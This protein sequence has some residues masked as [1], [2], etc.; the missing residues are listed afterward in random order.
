MLIL[1][2]MEIHLSGHLKK[3]FSLVLTKDQRQLKAL[4]PQTWSSLPYLSQASPNMS[5]LP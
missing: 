2:D 4:V 5:I 1:A 3:P